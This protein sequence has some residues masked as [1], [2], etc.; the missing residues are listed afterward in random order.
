VSHRRD[1]IAFAERI[2]YIAAQHGFMYWLDV[3]DPLLASLTG[4]PLPSPAQEVLIAAIIEIALLNSTHIISVHTENSDGSRW[5]PYEVGR[6][7]QRR[8]FWSRTCGWFHACGDPPSKAVVGEYMF[9]A[10]RTESETQLD[11]WCAQQ[12]AR[13]ARQSACR[14]GG[15]YWTKGAVPA[16]LPC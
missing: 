14:I 11:D 5:M 10:A 9:L 13:S 8:V 4:A 1:D 12:K 2:A 15:P 7:K 6:A 3:H 16:R